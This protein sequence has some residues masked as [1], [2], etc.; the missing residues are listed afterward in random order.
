MLVV[1]VTVLEAYRYK[2]TPEQ[3]EWWTTLIENTQ[4]DAD[5]QC[6]ECAG[7]RSRI[8]AHNVEIA[9]AG[10]AARKD[11]C[12]AE[13]ALKRAVVKLLAQ[14]LSDVEHETF[15]LPI[16]SD[17]VEEVQELDFTARVRADPVP[18]RSGNTLVQVPRPSSVTVE[19]GHQDDP[20][21]CFIGRKKPLVIQGAQLPVRLR[22]DHPP[23]KQGDFVVL[24]VET[25]QWWSLP[26][27]VGKVLVIDQPAE[28]IQVRLHGNH[29]ANALGKWYPAWWHHLEPA[30]APVKATKRRRRRP[31]GA[32]TRRKAK[33]GQVETDY[34]HYSD[35][36]PRGP[37]KPHVVTAGPDSIIDWGFEL[38]KSGQLKLRV[39]KVIDHNPRVGWFLEST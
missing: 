3:Q 11:A 27:Q 34:P 8:A 10:R 28:Q 19:A 39:L 17:A 22:K 9:A 35:K 4:A 20:W 15:R 31:A 2:M 26:W 16:L 5:E 7:F 25:D 29:K 6:V 33:K 32:S 23:V 14:H 21:P 36:K 37:F 13:K 18:V 1:R 12:N 24:R 30:Q 38:R